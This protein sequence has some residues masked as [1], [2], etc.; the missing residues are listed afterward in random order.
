MGVTKTLMASNDTLFNFE[1]TLGDRDDMFSPRTPSLGDSVHS[2]FS[3]GR[4][5][6]RTPVNDP[7]SS[8]PDTEATTSIDTLLTESS[9]IVKGSFKP[10]EFNAVDIV[11]VIDLLSPDQPKTFSDETITTTIEHV[12][13]DI[14]AAT[15]DV[16]F[17]TTNTGEEKTCISVYNLAKDD[18]RLSEI[19]EPEWAASTTVSAASNFCDMNTFADVTS[20]DMQSQ[21]INTTTGTETDF[22]EQ[23]SN[24]GTADKKRNETVKEMSIMNNTTINQNDNH[25]LSALKLC[26]TENIQ[27]FLCSEIDFSS[28]PNTNTTSTTISP[29]SSSQCSRLDSISNTKE[30]SD[31]NVPPVVDETNQSTN[32]EGKLS[33]TLKY[34][35]D[36]LCNPP[37][38][39]AEF[40]SGYGT[41]C[42]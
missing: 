22:V 16:T 3:S 13:S 30:N 17:T 24:N 9:D 28:I 7:Q 41:V 5:D 11:S 19:S 23:F 38:L 21:A 27:K 42:V 25:H 33:D 20:L 32:L 8:T 15:C 39:I 26:S 35:K 40:S 4:S 36:F 18:E 31:P 2:A 10:M 14:S 1:D 12:S 29:A 34:E 6:Q 37:D